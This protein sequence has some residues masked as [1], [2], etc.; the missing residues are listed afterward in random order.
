LTQKITALPPRQ[1][2]FLISRRLC[3]YDPSVCAD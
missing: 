3:P 1:S 2:G